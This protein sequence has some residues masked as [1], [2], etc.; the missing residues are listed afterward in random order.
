MPK[1]TYISSYMQTALKDNDLPYGLAY[2]NKVAYL[3]E[4]AEKSWK[5]YRK[6]K[7]LNKLN[8]ENNGKR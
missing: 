4:K 8:N 5:K 1:S 2:L 6:K 7:K 3:E